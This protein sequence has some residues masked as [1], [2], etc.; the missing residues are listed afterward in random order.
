ML[1]HQKLSE[2]SLSTQKNFKKNLERLCTSHFEEILTFV[3]LIK[4]I[5][6]ARKT[7]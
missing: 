2:T 4:K 3:F 6:F 1:E 5:F 7:T